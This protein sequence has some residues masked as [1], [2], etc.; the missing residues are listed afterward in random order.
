MLSFEPLNTDWVFNGSSYYRSL[1]S[2]QYSPSNWELFHRGENPPGPARAFST[3]YVLD[4]HPVNNQDPRNY[5]S[6]Y[7]VYGSPE[8]GFVRSSNGFRYIRYLV[9]P[10]IMNP[11]YPV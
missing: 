5:T 9:L 11:P 7:S 3:V 10:G 4:E 1:G 8:Y 2:L 6:G